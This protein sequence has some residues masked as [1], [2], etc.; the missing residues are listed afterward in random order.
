MER[1]LRYLEELSKRKALEREANALN[2]N[3]YADRERGFRVM[4]SGANHK[5]ERR[6]RP[7]RQ[8]ASARLG[9]RRARDFD[10]RR[11][12]REVTTSSSTSAK[13]DGAG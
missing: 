2:A 5:E 8:V 7:E 11:I 9:R 3:P 6:K 13:A 10:Q 4:W 1:N 12:R